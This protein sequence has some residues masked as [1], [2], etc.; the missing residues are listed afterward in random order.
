[1]VAYTDVQARIGR[2]LTPGEQGRVTAYIADAT[3][4]AERVVPGVSTDASKAGSFV[5]VICA[6]VIRAARLPDA[7]GAVVPSDEET[8]FPT[9]STFSGKVYFRKDELRSLGYRFNRAARVSPGPIRY[10]PRT[11]GNDCERW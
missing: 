8:G 9:T 11:F 4:E 7:L 1:M 6:A 3:A 10:W 2:P 5:S